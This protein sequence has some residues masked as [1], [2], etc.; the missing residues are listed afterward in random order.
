MQARDNACV[1]QLWSTHN[2][3]ATAVVP[4]LV[5]CFCQILE[6]LYTA[7]LE[8]LEV[9]NTEVRLTAAAHGETT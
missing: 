5:V 3:A 6:G 2:N 9:W 1:A 8:L 4:P 7:S